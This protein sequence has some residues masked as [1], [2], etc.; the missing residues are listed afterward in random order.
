MREAK[1]QHLATRGPGTSRH[2]R[3]AGMP[4]E[5]AS[6]PTG[7]GGSAAAPR[8]WPPVGSLGLADAAVG[9]AKFGYTYETE[10]PME[11]RVVRRDVHREVDSGAPRGREAW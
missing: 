3:P 7:E 10:G 11:G 5:R 8:R 4:R 1:E 2:R 6:A 9:M